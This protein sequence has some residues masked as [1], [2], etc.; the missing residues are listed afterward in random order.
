MDENVKQIF[1][2]LLEYQKKD[3]ELRKLNAVLERDEALI[4]MNKNKRAFN[5]AKQAI[6]D[7][8]QQAGSLLDT[9]AELQKYIEDNE[10]ALTELENNEVT[11][12]QE[13][14]S[15][16]RKLESLK[17]KF[18]SADKKM[19]DIGEKSR[20]VCKRR[21][22][23]LKSGNAAKQN[24]GEAREK[25]NKLVNSKADELKKLKDA[26]SELQKSLDPKLFEEYKK[27]VEDNKFPPIVPASGEEKKNLFNCGGCGLNLP[28]KGNAMLN[29]QGYCR[30]ENC[31]RIIVH[32]K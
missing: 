28:Q 10:A 9:F 18:Q 8:E 23:A 29:D 7:C 4:S 2:K 17:S 11:D 19:H 32:L 5:D 22:D 3:I 30:C 24:F 12:E 15:R 26:L 20:T 21:S 16:V 1:Q 14:E 27:L 6:A 31:R 13:L 25:H